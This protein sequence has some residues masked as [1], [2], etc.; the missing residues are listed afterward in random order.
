MKIHTKQRKSSIYHRIFGHTDSTELTA[1]SILKFNNIS[2]TKM[3]ATLPKYWDFENN[4]CGKSHIQNCMSKLKGK[5]N[6]EVKRSPRPAGVDT[7]SVAGRVQ[8]NNLV[9]TRFDADRRS[10]TP[11]VF[12][13]HHDPYK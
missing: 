13:E 8:Q 1:I 6:Q 2:T 10:N 7:A 9:G 5:L 12:R 3:P 11:P 4:N